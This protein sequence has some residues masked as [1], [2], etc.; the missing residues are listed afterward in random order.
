MLFVIS[1]EGIFGYKN[2]PN[3]PSKAIA[4]VVRA[5][6][7]THVIVFRIKQYIPIKRSIPQTMIASQK[8]EIWI[9]ESKNVA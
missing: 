7:N 5:A 4:T 9:N 8:K 6:R 2:T 3:P 1:D